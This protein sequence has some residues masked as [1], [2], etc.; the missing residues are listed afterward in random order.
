VW[1]AAAAGGRLSTA[2]LFRAALRWRAPSCLPFLAA[3][4]TARSR[5]LLLALLQQGRQQQHILP[6]LAAQ[7]PG[8]AGSHGRRRW[9]AALHAAHDWPQVRAL[10]RGWAACCACC[11]WHSRVQSMP[12]SAA[13]CQQFSYCHTHPGVHLC[14]SLPPGSTLPAH[15]P[16]CLYPP[17]GTPIRSCGAPPG[18]TM[19]RCSGTA[20]RWG[21]QT[22]Q[23]PRGSWPTA[24][25]SQT[26]AA[27]TS[28]STVDTPRRWV[29]G[30]VGGAVGGWV[31]GWL[32]C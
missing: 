30:W 7:L 4:L 20:P 5:P 3:P 11:A 24:C 17:A 13:C 12:G 25:A 22:G 10:P 14:S 15:L 26:A 19:A 31:S 27:C 2:L 32:S 8:L 28:H 21:H 1:V 23:S 6:R 29:G 18:S 16:A 9:P